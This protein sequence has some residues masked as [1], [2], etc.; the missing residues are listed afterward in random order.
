MLVWRFLCCV[1]Y[2]NIKN[3]NTSMKT[4]PVNKFLNV[5]SRVEDV[6]ISLHVIFSL[7]FSDVLKRQICIAY[8][9][10]QICVHKYTCQWMQRFH[11]EMVV[12]P[13]LLINTLVVSNI[14][15]NLVFITIWVWTTVLVWFSSL[16]PFPWFFFFFP[17][18]FLLPV[19]EIVMHSHQVD[20]KKNMMLKCNSSYN[21]N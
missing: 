4:T 5:D 9:Y 16:C 19:N 6:C 10:V 1:T 15:T 18:V 7:P 2:D 12:L 3:I 17:P 21:G 11:L 20:Y 8:Q 13:C 14:E